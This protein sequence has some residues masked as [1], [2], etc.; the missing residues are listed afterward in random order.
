MKYISLIQALNL[1]CNL[2][3]FGDWHHSTQDWDNLKLLDTEGSVLGD[4]GIE[5]NKTVPCHKEK[6]NVAN[7]L[8]A[9]LDMLYLQ[10]FTVARGMKD[11]YICT[12]EYDNELFDKVMLMKQLPYWENI[13]EFMSKEYLG[14]WNNYKRSIEK[15]KDKLK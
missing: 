10:H 13:D 2:N 9:V 6:Y 15:A 4:Y 11:D 8:R 12:D 14:K 7:H 1:P 3:T 5:K